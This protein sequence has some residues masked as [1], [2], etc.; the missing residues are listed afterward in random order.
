MAMRPLRY[1]RAWLALW[2]AMI[3]AVMVVS[4]IPSPPVP[5]V[6]FRGI[7]KVE[8]ILGYFALSS[9]AHA[10]FGPMPTRARVAGALV[11]MGVALEIAQGTMTAMRTPDLLDAFANAFGV[12]LG[13]ACTPAVR[14]VAWLDGRLPERAH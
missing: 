10:L 8:H 1:P 12:V 13:L 3:V 7:D 6:S 4:L 11:A 14:V 9:M 5:A 2:I